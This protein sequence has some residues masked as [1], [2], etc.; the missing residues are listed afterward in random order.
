MPHQAV[1]ILW[2]KLHILVLDSALYFLML[3][4]KSH[5]AHR[6]I[7]RASLLGYQLGVSCRLL[8]GH[9]CM[10][11]QSALLIRR[12]VVST[13]LWGFNHALPIQSPLAISSSHHK[14][15][16]CGNYEVLIKKVDHFQ[17]MLTDAVPCRRGKQ[18]Q[19]WMQSPGI[20]QWTLQ[21]AQTR[22]RLL[23]K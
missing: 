13:G 8:T 21:P 17:A 1:H 5:N 15:I 20:H 7:P 10:G 12:L 18:K 14:Q 16:V 22:Q 23:L 19:R 11:I 9:F 4:F 3:T 6:S 2:I